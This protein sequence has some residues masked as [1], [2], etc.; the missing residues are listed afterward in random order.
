LHIGRRPES[1]G[2]KKLDHSVR[3]FLIDWS[4]FRTLPMDKA[5]VGSGPLGGPEPD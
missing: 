4:N 3:K 2:K 5:S 1:E